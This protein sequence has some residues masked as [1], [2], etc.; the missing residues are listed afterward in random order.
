MEEDQEQS[1]Q[2]YKDRIGARLRDLRKKAGLT[3]A[4]L[5]EIVYKNGTYIGRIERGEAMRSLKLLIACSVILNT[6]LDYFIQDVPGVSAES[7]DKAF[8]DSFHSLDE[9]Q[10]RFILE[11]IDHVKKY[12]IA[13]EDNKLKQ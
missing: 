11:D 9:A 4:K 6:T 7:R 8:L 10:Q 12:H 13:A 1:L 3:Q 2:K 5:G